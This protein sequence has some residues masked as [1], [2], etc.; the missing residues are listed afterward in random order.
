MVGIVVHSMD[1]HFIKKNKAT[2]VGRFKA[3][4]TSSP[5]EQQVLRASVAARGWWSEEQR[6]RMGWWR[7]SGLSGS[8][9]AEI[10]VARCVNSSSSAP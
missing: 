4:W 8:A 1:F 5:P 6:P 7:R 10:H 2:R 3:D 9:L